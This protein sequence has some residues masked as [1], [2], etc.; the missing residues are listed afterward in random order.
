MPRSNRTARRKNSEAS[1][2]KSERFCFPSFFEPTTISWVSRRSSAAGTKE[3]STERSMSSEIRKGW[4]ARRTNSRKASPTPRCGMWKKVTGLKRRERSTPSAVVESVEPFEPMITSYSRPRPSRKSSRRWVLSTTI[5]SS[6][7]TGMPTVNGVSR[8]SPSPPPRRG[9]RRRTW[10]RACRRS[11]ARCRAT[12][13]PRRPDC[14]GGRG[15]GRKAE[16]DGEGCE[17]GAQH[18]A[19]HPPRPAAHVLDERGRGGDGRQLEDGPQRV[20]HAAA[21]REHAG[22]EDEAASG[23]EQ[24][25][26]RHRP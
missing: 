23:R 21:D 1:R 13:R 8:P 11:A 5:A 12:P 18:R 24:V 16:Y 26:E 14:R 7:K 9:A 3:R 25:A 15:H 4:R 22:E 2:R 10:P 17:R 19:P 20:E 6:S